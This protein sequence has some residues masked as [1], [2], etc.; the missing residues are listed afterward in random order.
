MTA[1]LLTVAALLVALLASGVWVGLGLA[2]VGIASLE[3]F[4]GFMPVD[5]LLAQT[6]WNSTTSAELVALPLFIL[7]G[8]LLFRSRLTQL[9]F[10]GLAPWVDRIPGRLLHTNVLG[11][12]LFAAISGSSAATTATV[13][14][15]T[16]SE[17]T[18]RGYDP[19]VAAGTLAGAGTLGFLIPPS[20]IMI[21]YGVLAQVSI[22][23]MFI[24]G[25]VPGLLLAAAFMSYIGIHA[26]L[27][28][29]QLPPRQRGLRAGDYLRALVQ[30]GPVALLIGFVIGSMLTGMAT[31]TEAGAVGVLGALVVCLLQR[32]LSWKSLWSALMGAAQ[33]TSM[34]GLIIVG[35]MFLSVAMGFLSVPRTIADAIASLELAPLALIALLLVFFVV[36]GTLLEGMSIIVMTLP[37]TLPLI[38][39][40]GFDPIWFGVFLVLVVEMAQITPPVGFNL[41][42]INGIT[43]MKIGQIARAVLPFFLIMVAFTLLLAV[44]PE[45]VTWLPNHLQG[46]G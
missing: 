8:E 44:V 11:C 28:P 19:R 22:L 45:I 17:L 41:F 38:V 1:I 30:L 16:A 27:N 9:L 23:K 10:D 15:I 13:G 3:V 26:L 7:M 12:T 6:V 2:G 35:A 21:I 37:I 25:I 31:P 29:G 39:Q 32:C 24:A 18:Q 5:K 43:G 14:R 36:L 46:R 42:V 40:A 20:T 4:R 33:I 34:I